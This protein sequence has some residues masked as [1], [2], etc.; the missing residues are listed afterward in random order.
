MVGSRSALKPDGPRWAPADQIF[1]IVTEAAAIHTQT[2][3]PAE[4]PRPPVRLVYAHSPDSSVW[5][6]SIGQ[7]DS[8]EQRPYYLSGLSVSVRM[9]TPNH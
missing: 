9:Y 2:L 5:L 1:P 7:L 8:C 6:D 3:T 4:Q